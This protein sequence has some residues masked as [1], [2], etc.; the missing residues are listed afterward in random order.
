M[1]RQI[2]EARR[3]VVKVGSALVTNNG[4]GLALDFIAECA[5]QIAALHA[6]GRQVLL[7]SSGAIAAGM[8]RLG[9]ASARHARSASS[10]GGG[11][12]G[13]GAGL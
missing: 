11:P 9:Y 6:D 2:A 4:Q 10:S 5:R 3:V 12:N 7:V 8:Q 13:P 1:R